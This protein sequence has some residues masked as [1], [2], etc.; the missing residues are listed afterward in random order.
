[1]VNLVMESPAIG[2]CHDV[3]F[4]FRLTTHALIAVYDI[5]KKRSFAEAK[6]L[7]DEFAQRAGLN[8]FVAL[9]GNKADLESRREV[10]FEISNVAMFI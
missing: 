4:T 10:S 6:K 3:R 9:V 1:M 5:T 7:V 8:A 2:S